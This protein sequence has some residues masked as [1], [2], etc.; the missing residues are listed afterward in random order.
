MRS[1]LSTL[2]V[3]AL[4]AELL[5]LLGHV[6]LLLPFEVD[7]TNTQMLSRVKAGRTEA[8][9]MAAVHQT[10]GRG[11]MGKAWASTPGQSLTFSLGLP[12][13]PRDWSGL[14]LV[15]GTVLAERLH[16][17]I[18][19]KWPN[20]LW[21][22]PPAPRKLAGILIETAGI[23]GAGV[24]ASGFD[25]RGARPEETRWCVVG[26]GINVGLPV[27]SA[28]DPAA[29]AAAAP[30][31]PARV[32]PIQPAALQELDADAQVGS[33]LCQ[34]LTPLVRALLAFEAHGFG[35]WRAR[36]SARDA[37]LGQ[38]LILSDGRTGRAGGVDASGALLVHTASGVV[39]VT[40]AD[41]SVRP[42]HSPTQSLPQ[43]P[44]A[45]TRATTF[46]P[47]P[48]PSTG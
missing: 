41:V 6:E 31:H 27:A 7:S 13:A 24:A 34:V 10:A 5:P 22:M 9:V 3:S 18:R 35:P 47:A 37:L 28:M 17:S 45:Q 16:P 26:V 8:C 38:D 29:G 15:V 48:C 39:A 46:V 1:V 42:I 11:R 44:Q 2:Q 33:V 14:S 32:P 4:Q 25:R 23:E 21:V 12:L 43:T 19:L 40:S 30:S 20:D 36:F